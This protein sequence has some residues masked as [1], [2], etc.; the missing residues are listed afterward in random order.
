M[1]HL[2]RVNREDVELFPCGFCG[3]SGS[4]T[5]S[6]QS[7]SKIKGKGFAKLESDCFYYLNLT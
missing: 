7:S 5:T 1:R 6:I 3:R 2:L 4:C